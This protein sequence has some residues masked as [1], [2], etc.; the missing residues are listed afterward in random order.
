MYCLPLTHFNQENVRSQFG[1][2]AVTVKTH[3]STKG[4]QSNKKH[5]P[6]PKTNKKKENIEG[7]RKFSW[8]KKKTLRTV[9]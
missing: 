5:H 2:G 1:I 6:T 7:I 9:W 8:I 3:G 4:K